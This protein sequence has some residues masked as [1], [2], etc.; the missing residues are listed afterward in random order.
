MK[1]SVYKETDGA[2]AVLVQASPGSG[3][4]PLVLPGLT[5]GTLKA[6][7]LQAV[8]DMRGKPEPA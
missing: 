6:A 1:V 4:I 2:L 8:K 5:K 3:R 7:V